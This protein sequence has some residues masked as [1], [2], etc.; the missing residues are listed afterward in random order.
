M[1][2]KFV[3]YFLRHPIANQVVDR[4]VRAPPI[5]KMDRG[6]NY[7]WDQASITNV[8]QPRLTY[9]FNELRGPTHKNS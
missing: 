3:D 5:R 2:L 1:R 7:C 8:A 4:Q 6:V 9:I